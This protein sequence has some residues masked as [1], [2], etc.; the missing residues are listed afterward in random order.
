MKSGYLIPEDSQGQ[1]I[2]VSPTLAESRRSDAESRR[3]RRNARRGEDDLSFV[4]RKQRRRPT[5]PLPAKRRQRREASLDRMVSRKR[6][7]TSATRNPG[8]NFNLNHASQKKKDVEIVRQG[9][10]S[11]AN[12]RKKE[13]AKKL[14]PLYERYSVTVVYYL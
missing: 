4:E 14:V 11:L 2:R 13:P 12:K 8:M 1:V 7:K 6:R 10:K 9:K 5:P 3:R